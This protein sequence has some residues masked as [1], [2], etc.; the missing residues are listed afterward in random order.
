MKKA[1]SV[2]I[3]LAATTFGQPRS[4]LADYAVILADAPVAQK[5][6]S[7][8]ALRSPE[9]VAEVA[10][11][12]GLQDNVVAELRRRK[13]VVLGS[14]QTLVNAIFVTTDRDT[15][16]QLLSL[17][18][19][20]HVV[21]TP[22]LH[23]ELDRALNLQN[24]PAAWSAVGGAANAG[25]GIKIGIIDSGIDQNHAG[26]QDASLTPPAG[27]PKG[28]ANYTNKK[29][30]VARSYVASLS[31]TDVRFSAPDDTSPRDR[32]GHGTAIAMIAAG[33]QNTGPAGTIQ[34]V[35]PKAFLGNYKIFGSPGLNDF[36][37]FV[38]FNQALKDAL[39]DGMDI[40]TLSLG[41]G[42][43]AFFGPLDVDPTC[44]DSSGNQQCDVR[45]QAVENAI[46]NGMTVV[47]A[48]GNDGN[49]NN[50]APT[51]DTIHTPGTAPS[52]ITVGAVANSHVFYQAVHVTGSGVPGNLQ[53][54]RALFSD[55]PHVASA[56]TAPIKDVAQ[57]GNDGL[58]CSALPAGSLTG[59][60]ALIQRGTCSF[61]DKLVNTQ[62][63]GAIGGIIYQSAGQEAIYSG[64]LVQ[65]T[66]IPSMM[67]G[68][69][70][71]TALK[72]YVDANAGAKV[73]LDPALTASEATPSTVWAASSRG[74]SPGTFASKQTFV[75]KP[76][77]VA[78]G[79]NVYTATQK[80][81]PNGDAYD[82]TGYTSVTGTSYAVP[83]V[84]GAVALVKQ[85]FPSFTPAQLKSAVV[86]TATQ[87]VSDESATPARVNSVG[88]G[89]LSAGDA[90][91]AAATLDPATIEFGAVAAG[92]LPIR[93]TLNITN[94]GSSSATFNFAVQARDTS[95][96]SVQVSPTSVNL[97]AGQQSSVTVTLS[98][99]RPNAGSYEGFILVTG[100]G[101]TLRLP[102]QYLVGTNIPAAA[103]TLNNGGFLGGTNDT[104]WELDLRVVD[105]YGVP[106]V[107]V[108]VTFKAVSGG[109]VITG[110]DQQS[111]ALGNSAVFVNLGPTQGGQIFNATVGGLTTEFDGFARAYPAISPNQVVDAATGQVGKGLAPGSYI[112][113]YGT[114]LADA[115]N[116]EST[117]SLP[118]SLSS[119]SVS[120]DGGGLSLPGH[121]HFVSPGQ[122]NVQIP[123][124]FLGQTSVQMKVTVSDYLS[125]NVYTV[126]LAA[127]SPGIFEYT[128]NGRKSVVAQDVA[129]NLISQANAAQ[130]GKAI[131]IYANGLGAVSNQ[132]ASGEPSPAQPLAATSV[133]PVVTIGGVTAQVVFSGLTPGAVGLYQVNVVVPSSLSPGNQTLVISVNGLPS[134][135]SN[136]A[137][138]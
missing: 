119:V 78:V 109:G 67:I 75:I 133:L 4:R 92:A 28:D 6:R 45:A 49:I 20:A 125:S 98:G 65:S 21:R 96:A 56:L 68:F 46:A 14:D 136:I 77:L 11:I 44:A 117:P 126:P 88:A 79:V 105:A 112:S 15:A 47:V 103:Y 24:V 25:A 70:D 93:R 83:M 97:G 32:V 53:N 114:A 130:R 33:V 58:A 10:R 137:V 48:A 57:L 127:S 69:T 7:R 123:W 17:P 116:V 120:F 9:S 52:A 132:P 54:I 106:V 94:T 13:I 124:E 34:G 121:I 1:L 71:G 102:F 12:C 62:L 90:V 43:G 100:A 80:L 18:G 110:G 36:T 61:T 39:A 113:I 85:K 16:A 135:T 63:A 122:V 51:L 81:D 84:A 29:V 104:R 115:T 27:F 35:A 37:Y 64:L 108:P 95:A 26:F 22:R 74:P 42:D 107:G 89:K 91:N 31:S 50:G 138:Q 30:I 82:P 118:V 86:N 8:I 60:I 23:M 59:A 66:G 129:F 5:T 128:D 41:G 55:G 101:P 40:V 134:Q 87:D 99:S 38:A 111:F 72:S 131:Q 19:V 73:S 76:E 3:L 2:M